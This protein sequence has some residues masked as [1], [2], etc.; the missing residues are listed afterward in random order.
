[1][2]PACPH[3]AF[4]GYFSRL[5]ACYLSP[6]STSNRYPC[7]FVIHIELLH[8]ASVSELLNRVARCHAGTNGI[9]MIEA[10]S[11]GGATAKKRSPRKTDGTKFF[12]TNQVSN[13]WGW[14]TE[15]VRRAIREGRIASVIIS[16][17]RL[18]PVAEIERIEAEG[19][20]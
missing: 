3:A 8:V 1:M 16:R 18:I 9:N 10:A 5:L 11:T 2:W 15:S 4:L 19:A 17:R 14:H 12:T 7:G 20:I 13:R 6:F